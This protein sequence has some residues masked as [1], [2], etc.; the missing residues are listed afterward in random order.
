MPNLEV[1]KARNGSGIFTTKLFKKGRNLFEVKGKLITCNEDDEID[2]KTRNNTFRFDQDYFIS[3]IG[4][5]GEYLNHSCNP[6]SRVDKINGKI[7]I[8]AIEDLPGASEV[9]IDYSTIQ[10]SDDIWT[11]K[12]NC[13][14]KNCRKTIKNIV[15]ISK[16]VRAHYLKYGIIPEY[17]LKIK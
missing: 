17:I 7:Y 4:K 10:A 11:M 9:L 5:I 14:S 12:C 8:I 2:E 6:N 16:K 13:G 1:K 15:K 3:P